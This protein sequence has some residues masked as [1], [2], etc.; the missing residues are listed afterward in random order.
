VAAELVVDF[1]PWVVLKKCRPT[2]NP[3]AYHAYHD[4]HAASIDMLYIECKNVTV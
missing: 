3:V 2:V 4:V 1:S